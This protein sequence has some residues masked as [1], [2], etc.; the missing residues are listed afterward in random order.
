MELSQNLIKLCKKQNLSLSK[1]S[2]LSGVPHQTLHGWSLG[3]KSVR[4]AQ[5]KAVARALHVSV[6]ELAYG[7]PDP[8]ESIGE[9]ILKELFTG[10]VR[11][12]VHRIERRRTK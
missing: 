8:N 7:E 11:V 2:V 1:L 3:R 12:T 10:D 9:E 6:H 5:L 4:L